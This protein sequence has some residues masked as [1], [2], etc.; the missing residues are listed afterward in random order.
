MLLRPI[1][2]S[3]Q[4]EIDEANEAVIDKAEEAAGQQGIDIGSI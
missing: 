3:T 1:Q 2:S 4:A